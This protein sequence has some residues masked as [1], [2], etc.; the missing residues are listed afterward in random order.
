MT[1]THLNFVNHDIE[2]GMVVGAR[3]WAFSGAHPDCWRL[4]WKGVVLALDDPRAW[5]GT[6]AFPGKRAPSRKKVQ[7]HVT[8]CREQGL[9]TRSV[10]VLWNFGEHGQ[11]V[12]WECATQLR[13]YEEDV[14]AWREARAQAYAQVKQ[15][16]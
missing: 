2:P 8:W 11:E 13:S 12:H 7:A 14:S 4:P 9:L 1:Q 16:A 3:R 10:P 15:A 5:K 6:M